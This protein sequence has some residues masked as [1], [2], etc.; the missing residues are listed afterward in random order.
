MGVGKSHAFRI[1]CVAQAESMMPVED[2]ETTN[3]KAEQFLESNP[4]PVKAGM[5]HTACHLNDQ[6][7]FYA[8]K[9]PELNV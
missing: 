4:H 6:F 7:I 1:P 8:S 5:L 9:V 3:K 2:R